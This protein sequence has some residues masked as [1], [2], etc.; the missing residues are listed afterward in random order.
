MQQDR[1]NL[2][3]YLYHKSLD[4]IA[5]YYYNSNIQRIK[6][7]TTIMI[8][9]ITI[10]KAQEILAS[11]LRTKRLVTGLTQKGLATRSGVALATLRKFEQKGLISLESFLKLLMVLGGIDEII[12]AV[13]LKQKEFL[14]IDD[15]LKSDIENTRKKGWRI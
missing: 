9:L 6:R 4:D 5:I 10:T 1:Y 8:S 12:Q 7:V 13:E 14:S 15:V 2:G 11:Q 3:L